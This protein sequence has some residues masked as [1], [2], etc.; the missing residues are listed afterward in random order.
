[1]T[2][3]KLDLVEVWLKIAISDTIRVPCVMDIE[4]PMGKSVIKILMF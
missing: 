1:M 3:A 4:F 2:K